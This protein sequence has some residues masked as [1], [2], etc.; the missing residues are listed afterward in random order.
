MTRLSIVIP[1]Y[2]AEKTIE[3][4][5]NT[6]ISLYGKQYALEIVLVN[7][8]SR[9]S[10]DIICRRLHAEHAATIKYIKLARN[11]GEHN[12]VIAGLNYVTGDF[13][14]TMDDDF[15]NPPEEIATL[16][17][18]I[19]RG[20]DVVYTYY[21]TKNDP[22]Y[23]NLGS[24]FNDAMANF[25]LKKP[26][27]LYLSSFKIM[28]RFVV[29]QIIKYTG[30]DPYID[31]II[32][33]V[34]AE[35]G[36]VQVRHSKREHGRSGYT[37]GKLVSLWGNMIVSYSLIPLRVLGVCG[38]LLTVYGIAVGMDTFV[39]LA[40]PALEDPSELEMMRASTAFFRGVQLLA[41]SVVGEY[42]GRIYLL[43]RQDPQYIIREAL[44]H[45]NAPR[46]ARLSGHQEHHEHHD[47]SAKR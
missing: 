17:A 6:L 33:R 18:E 40:L 36:K 19:A 7:D 45:R 28:N 23:R 16:L 9:D 11:F 4:L 38:M 37:F 27:D 42:V 25:V 20:F 13:C 1:V 5:C 47:N 24:R 35:I 26:A 41:T 29:D 39:S 3:S 31:G 15:Q 14:V 10:T 44:P 30:P 43:S 21:D 2:N 32:L 34:T 46:I 12:A 8:Y 22:F